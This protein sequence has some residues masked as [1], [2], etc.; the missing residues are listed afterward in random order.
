[1]EHQSHPEGKE[2]MS[3]YMGQIMA[4]CDCQHK[5]CEVRGYC[6]AEHIKEVE[7]QLV[8]MSVSRWQVEPMQQDALLQDALAR[9]ESAE[10]KLQRWVGVLEWL[11]DD[12]ITRVDWVAGGGDPSGE[13]CRLGL[14]RTMP[15]GT[16]LFRTYVATDEWTPRR[17]NPFGLG[18]DGGDA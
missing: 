4:E 2:R 14:S 6:M 18:I 13:F 1:M 12:T 7:A 11:D 16:E 10:A 17:P 15:D 8:G 5:A 9:A 3:K